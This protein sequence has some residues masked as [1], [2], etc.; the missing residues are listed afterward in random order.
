M[1]FNGCMDVGQN[2]A[3][4][5]L[6]TLQQTLHLL[7]DPWD[8]ASAGPSSAWQP[9]FTLTAHGSPWSL[10]VPIPEHCRETM[11]LL[12]LSF[13]GEAQA[14]SC[15][16]FVHHGPLQSTPFPPQEGPR[17][18]APSAVIVPTWCHQPTMAL[19]WVLATCVTGSLL[20]GY[21]LL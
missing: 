5:E 9:L 21:Y 12:R 8:E 19:V 20:G 17:L 10:S 15:M 3:G 7:L 4:L 14:S 2:W 18:V 16:R 1:W 6:R 13:G 11:P